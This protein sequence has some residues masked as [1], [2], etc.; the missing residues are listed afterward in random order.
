[1]AVKDEEL[2]LA[3]SIASILNQEFTN[4]ELLIV[5]DG[6]TDKTSSIIRKCAEEDS[7]I[8]DLGNSG[9]IGLT[10]SLNLLIDHARGKIITRQDGDDIS[11]K[12]RLSDQLSTFNKNPNIVL[13]GT[14]RTTIDT[15]GKFLNNPAV[16]YN[17]RRI[18]SLLRYGNVFTHGSVMF[19]KKHFYDVGKYDER[20]KYSQDFDLWLRLSTKGQLMNIRKRLYKSRYWPQSI[21][22]SKREEQTAY[23]LLA[24]LKK[25]YPHTI[26]ES[27]VFEKMLSVTDGEGS[28]FKIILEY[29]TI[30]NDP[31][32]YSLLGNAFL[33][34][35]YPSYAHELL[36]KSHFFD[37]SKIWISK[38]DLLF[39][40][41]KKIFR[42]VTN[43]LG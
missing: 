10:K 36:K 37:R 21:S 14:G 29:M 34:A 23:A 2:F 11:E 20:F 35:G 5:D 41:A 26:D 4:L 38:N 12:N 19:K 40:F 18:K 16:I 3:D 22:E 9:G 24:I 31:K 43:P 13:L 33:R 6:S 42:I 28:Y 27:G 15:K 7:R 32:V 30:I 25:E 1:M 17:K 8:V 39:K